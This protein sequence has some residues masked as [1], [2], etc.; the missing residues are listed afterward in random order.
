MICHQCAVILCILTLGA[1][2]KSFSI[3]LSKIAV[4]VW[5][6]GYIF[7]AVDKLIFIDVGSNNH[8]ILYYGNSLGEALGSMGRCISLSNL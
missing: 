4:A 7:A 8:I 1:E 2:N 3:A 5:H 6:A